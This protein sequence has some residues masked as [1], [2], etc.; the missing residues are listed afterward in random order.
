MSLRPLLTHLADDPNGARLAREGGRA[1]VASSLRPY[2]IAALLDGPGTAGGAG[3]AH[4]LAGGR[5]ALVAAGDDRQAKDLAAD[6]R[7]WLRPRPV[8]F[9]P[10]R[11]VAYE[12][13]L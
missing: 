6:L 1:F 11:G 12:S 3:G 2:L 10:S 7:A 5:P 8:R 13:H 4:A 9:Y